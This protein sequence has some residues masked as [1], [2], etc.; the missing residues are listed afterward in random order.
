MV[1]YV[2]NPW[3]NR[4]EMLLVRQH[5]YGGDG[6]AGEGSEEKTTTARRRRRHR[7]QSAVARVSMW[8][9]RGHCPHMAESTALLVA[10]M[11]SDEAAA[12]D[13]APS[14]IYAVR[15]AYAAAFSRY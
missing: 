13:P 5:F 1:Q 6:G 2:F 8:M 9:A 7:Q 10:A 14:S 15:A 4:R 11:L 12:A 3:R